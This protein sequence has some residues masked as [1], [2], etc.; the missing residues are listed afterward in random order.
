MD[1][2][3]LLA[4]QGAPAGTAV[5]AE[6]QTGGRGSRGRAWH[7]PPGGL[8]LSV[9]YR[10]ASA[11][12]V[13]LMSLRLGLRLAEAL[14][15]EAPGLDVM[16][17]WPNDLFV[18]DR[19]LGG[20]LCEARWH[21]E[22][23]AWVVAGLGVN[24]ANAI[25]DELRRSAT[26]LHEHLPGATVDGLLGRLLE[27]LRHP[28][29]EAD[30]LTAAESQ[31]LVRRDWLRGR[32]LTAPLVGR[33]EGIGADGTLAVRTADGLTTARAGHVELAD[34]SSTG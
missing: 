10:P 6:A 15:A 17:K 9:L 5:L 22:V 12:G 34:Q 8:W 24:V 18:E 25:P 33:A 16:L 19:K 30:R 1:R 2:L 4:E 11:A 27:A 31:G 20:I 21:G 23:P 14:E 7:S 3:H 29:P 13:E 26:A 32:T 28:L